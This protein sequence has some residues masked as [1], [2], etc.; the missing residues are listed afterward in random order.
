[1]RTL[2]AS[3]TVFDG[4][5]APPTPPVDVLLEDGRIAAVGTGLSRSDVEVIDG[6]G[7]YLIPGLWETEA[8][9]TRYSNGILADMALDWPE[10]GDMKRVESNMRSY[11]ANGFTTIV[12]LGGPTEVLAEVRERQRRGLSPGPRLLMVGRQLNP[13][14]GLPLVDGRPLLSVVREVAT[15]E[16]ARTAV[17]ETVEAYGIDA[18][19]ANYTDN[20][21]TDQVRHPVHSRE[22]LQA[23]VAE[24]HAH[25]LPVLVHIDSA[26]LAVSALEAGVDNVEHMF[27]PNPETFDQDVERVTELCVRN[28]AYWPMT[29]TFW[30]AFARF[31]DPKFLDDLDLQGTIDQRVVDELTTDP[32]SLWRLA[33]TPLQERMRARFTAAMEHVAA[34]ERAG[35]K[36]TIATD[37]GNPG[38][39]HGP[40]ARREMLLTRQAGVPAASVLRAATSR[41]AEKLRVLDRVGTV[42]VG[43]I[44]D[45]VLLEADPLHDISNV[46]RITRV[47]QAGVVHDPD[48]LKAPPA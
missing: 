20:D 33:P 5:G 17:R 16:S 22:V 34:I 9:I 8:H 35:V 30:E 42:A 38:V 1:M 26:E 27:A 10:Q 19:K 7:K 3:V 15:A 41:S 48:E 12:D 13:P 6:T 29:I 45:L 14:G 44:A 43:K 46:G 47:I 24:A 32:G 11:L 2:I 23:I 18:V 36:L 4:T 39:F 28:G 37:A 21:G 40:S 31:G 25:N